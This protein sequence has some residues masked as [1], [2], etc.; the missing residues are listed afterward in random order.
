MRFDEI[1]RIA[2]RRGIRTFGVKKTEII[3][4][5]QMAE[6]NIDCFGTNRVSHCGE[7]GCLWRNDCMV[8]EG[9]RER[10]L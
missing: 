3:R 4:S 2:K 5:I 6:N 1:R 9:K 8:A 7:E 10:D